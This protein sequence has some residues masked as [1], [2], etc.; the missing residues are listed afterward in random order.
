MDLSNR[1]SRK[2]LK[3]HTEPAVLA[4]FLV[5]SVMYLS[6]CSSKK[7]P[8]ETAAQK[9]PAAYIVMEKQL[10]DTCGRP[11]TTLKILI[12]KAGNDGEA[13]AVAL[14]DV[15]QQDKTLNAVIIWAYRKKDELNASNYTV[16][17]LE[18]SA[19]GKDFNGQNTLT[20]NPKIDLVAK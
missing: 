18:W 10:P 4:F 12:P 14:K 19:D 7:V 13:L 8:D 9:S 1:L 20:P 17:R 2:S 3:N 15:R 6:A 16:G 5:L 11:C